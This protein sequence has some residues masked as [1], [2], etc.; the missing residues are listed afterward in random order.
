[1]AGSRKPT[2]RFPCFVLGA[3]LGIIM[4]IYTMRVRLEGVRLAC[5]GAVGNAFMR[6]C[7]DGREN[8]QAKCLDRMRLLH[9]EFDFM[10][11]FDH[12]SGVMEIPIGLGY[13]HVSNAGFR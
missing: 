8:A 11:G 4:T 10:T 6:G 1:M 12:V 2:W 7:V 5:D 3:A 13:N 9:K